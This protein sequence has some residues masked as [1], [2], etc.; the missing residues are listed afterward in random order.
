MT[1]YAAMAAKNS[2]ISKDGYTPCQRLFGTDVRFPG[3]TDEEERL[4]FAEALGTEGEV[5]RA[6]R[7]RLTAGKALLRSDVQEKLRRAILRRPAKGQGPFLPGAQI[8]F[9]VIWGS[10]EP[11]SGSL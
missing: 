11:S 9:W 3:V 7:M 5:A 4:S 6:H 10:T 1:G 2:T 8:Y